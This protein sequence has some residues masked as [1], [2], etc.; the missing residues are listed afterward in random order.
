MFA[1]A[2]SAFDTVDPFRL[3]AARFVIASVVFMLVLAVKEGPRALLPGTR[4]A[5]LWLT[6]TVGFAGFN[7]LVY[8]GLELST[9]QIVSLVMA[10]VPMVTLFVMWIRT[11]RRPRAAVFGL[12]AL[13]VFGIAMVLG[14]GKPGAVLE[15][16]LGGG[17]ALAFGGVVAW[18]VYTTSRSKFSELSL[19]RFTTLTCALGSTSVVAVAWLL[20]RD[21]PRVTMHDLV[22]V[23]PQIVYM[24]LPAT[25]LAVLT[26]NHAVATLGAG[27]GVLFMNLVPLTAFGVEWAR[28]AHP[29]GGQIAGGIVTLAALVATNVVMRRPSPPAT[30]EGAAPSLE[31]DPALVGNLADQSQPGRDR[32]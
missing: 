30:N 26:W 4:T 31:G 11:G 12:A 13:A 16:G 32:S 10:T 24:A 29:T 19:L 27:N 2:K 5:A 1:V 23:S 15:A 20:A 9:P 18:V 6:G 14:D 28:G 17:A 8:A 7:L 22:A 25:V 21:R 3:T